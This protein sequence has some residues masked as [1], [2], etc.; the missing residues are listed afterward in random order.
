[1]ASTSRYSSSVEYQLPKL[2]RRVRFP[3]PA[4]TGK[5]HEFKEN[6]E[7]LDFMGFLLLIYDSDAIKY[8]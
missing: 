3:L 4:L 6:S 5:A 1:M 2:G 7:N 8:D